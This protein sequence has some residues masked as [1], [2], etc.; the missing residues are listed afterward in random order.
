[1]LC[2]ALREKKTKRNKEEDVVFVLPKTKKIGEEVVG[3]LGGRMSTV[4]PI[5]DTTKRIK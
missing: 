4:R 5:Y 2:G 1:M 3:Q